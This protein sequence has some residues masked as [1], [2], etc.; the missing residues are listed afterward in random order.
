M[1]KQQTRRTVSLNRRVFAATKQYA[2]R[3]GVSMS[4]IVEDLLLAAIGD[5]QLASDVERLRKPVAERPARDVIAVASIATEPSPPRNPQFSPGSICALCTGPAVGALH[6]E[7][8]G[9]NDAMVNVCAACATEEPRER[10][11]LFGGSAG[12]GNRHTRAAGTGS[13]R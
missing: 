2:E 12:D 6:R 11:H 13:T 1:A 4:R 10:E 9:R 5:A 3:K 7:P 8:L